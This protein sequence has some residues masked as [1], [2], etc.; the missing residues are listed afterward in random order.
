MN[1]RTAVVVAAAVA[2]ASCSSPNQSTNSSCVSPRL[3]ASPTVSP[4]GGRIEVKGEWFLKSCND[5][6]TTGGS[7]LAGSNA[8]G[9]VTLAVTGPDNVTRPLVSLEPDP[10]G[11]FATDLRLPQDLPAGRATLFVEGHGLPVTLTVTG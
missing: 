9:S 8:L 1:F 4:V 2:V 10:S 6:Q 3:S 7:P 5:V 11:N